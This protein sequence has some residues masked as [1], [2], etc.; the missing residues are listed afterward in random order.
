[1]TRYWADYQNNQK[2][3]KKIAENLSSQ[4]YY[5]S[6]NIKIQMSFIFIDCY[7]PVWQG[8][9]FFF[10]FCNILKLCIVD[11]FMFFSG[12]GKIQGLLL[13]YLVFNLSPNS[14]T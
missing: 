4:L 9:V 11:R 6:K 3:Q 14:I 1:M 13:K 10:L 2:I 5:K 8:E 12:P 7:D